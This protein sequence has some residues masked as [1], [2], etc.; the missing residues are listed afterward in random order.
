MFFF[1][2][3]YRIVTEDFSS[4]RDFLWLSVDIVS[5]P[6]ITINGFVFSVCRFFSVVSLLSG[7]F[8][9]FRGFCLLSEDGIS[10]DLFFRRCPLLLKE[11]VPWLFGDVPW[12]RGIFLHFDRW[13]TLL[14]NQNYAALIVAMIDFVK[15]TLDSENQLEIII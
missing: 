11:D 12:L 14:L 9:L 13:R 4:I 7:D 2:N 8:L 1:Y 15:S 10:L 6:G 3:F 5:F